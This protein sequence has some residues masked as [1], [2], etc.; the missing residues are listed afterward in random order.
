[1]IPLCVP[2]ISGNEGK[3]LA[4]CV[5]STYVSTIGPFVTRFEKMVADA[6]GTAGA[7]ATSAGTA[8]LHAALI[9]V[10]VQRDDL[11]ICPSLTFI[12]SA[13][14]ISHAG[15]IPWLFDVDPASWTLDPLLLGRE[16]RERTE[17]RD[18]VRVHIDTGRRVSAIVPVFTLGVPAEMDAIVSIAHEYALKVVVDGAAALGSLYKGK[19]SGALGADLTMYSFNG[20]KTTTAGG[21]GAVAGDDEALLARFRH[22]TTTGRVGSDYDH[23]V[24]AYNYRMTNIQAAVGCAQ[25]ERLDEFVAAKRRIAGRYK[26]AFV[27]L[28]GTGLFP[29]PDWATSS[30]W[31]SGIAFH[32]NGAGKRSGDL[33]AHLRENGIDARP[34]WKPMHNQAPYAATPRTAMSTTDA[35]WPGIVT[36]PCSTHLKENDQDKVIETVLAWFQG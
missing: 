5:S 4:E 32:G 9:A 22:L 14:A 10:G 24:V 26:S 34:F 33:R 29:D 6:A 3:Y 12:A 19:S 8:A 13:N 18:G 11:V 7:A 35:L 21:G 25:M 1:M 16:L 17:R 15:A 31:F 27:G 20:N 30:C 28:N 2:N 36:L 23:D